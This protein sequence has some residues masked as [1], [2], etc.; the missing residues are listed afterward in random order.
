MT[1]IAAILVF[2]VTPIVLL[3][4]LVI[5]PVGWLTIGGFV[6]LVAGTTAALVARDRHRRHRQR[7]PVEACRAGTDDAGAS[8]PV[9]RGSGFGSWMRR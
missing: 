6:F 3:A 7:R 5:L 9:H 4:A 8:H 1:W 2:V